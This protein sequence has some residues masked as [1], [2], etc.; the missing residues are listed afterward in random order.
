MNVLNNPRR[1]IEILT[2]AREL[3]QDESKWIKGKFTDGEGCYCA[4]GATNRAEDL[5]TFWSDGAVRRLTSYVVN[6]IDPE[7]SVASFNDDP[8]TTH[9]SVLKMFDHVIKE[10][11]LA[12]LQENDNGN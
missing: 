11:H 7:H 2:R 1:D 9:A 12:I 8:A 4:L 5:T 6:N 10:T 3:I